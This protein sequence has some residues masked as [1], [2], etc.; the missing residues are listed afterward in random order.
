[1][2]MGLA[3]PANLPLPKTSTVRHNP[4]KKMIATLGNAFNIE[5]CGPLQ[6][7]LPLKPK[8]TEGGH[9]EKSVAVH[10]FPS[11]AFISNAAYKIGF[12]QQTEAKRG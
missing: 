5:T 3:Y 10:S 8:L 11:S 2:L 6:G 12:L 4:L 9:F 7:S 1:M